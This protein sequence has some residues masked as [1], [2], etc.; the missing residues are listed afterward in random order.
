MIYVFVVSLIF[1]CLEAVID[2][3]RK[4]PL[5]GRTGI[6]NVQLLPPAAGTVPTLSTTG[7]APVGIPPLAVA[8]PSGSV[9]PLAHLQSVNP[10]NGAPRGIPPPGIPPPI[11]LLRR[12]SSA[13]SQVSS[14]TTSNNVSG[15]GEQV[16]AK[17][18]DQF[19]SKLETN[20]IHNVKGLVYTD[21]LISPVSLFYQSSL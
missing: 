19:A 14:V 9:P 7:L 20:I 1:D 11:N 2:R 12:T 6:T 17:A 8:P 10:G 13:S 18:L 3:I 16:D 4:D 15:N 21:E 5:L